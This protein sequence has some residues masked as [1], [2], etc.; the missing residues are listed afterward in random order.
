MDRWRISAR[1]EPSGQHLTPSAD[2][3]ATEDWCIRKGVMLECCLPGPLGSA[4]QV[5]ASEKGGADFLEE[6]CG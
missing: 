4:G 2:V 3:V 5:H 1:G 6:A